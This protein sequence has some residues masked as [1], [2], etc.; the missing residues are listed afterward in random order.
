MFT[1]VVRV[2]RSR[3]LSV[4]SAFAIH[5]AWPIVVTLFEHLKC[6]DRISQYVEIGGGGGGGVEIELLL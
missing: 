3:A 5:C 2:W 6:V 1:Q 4:Y